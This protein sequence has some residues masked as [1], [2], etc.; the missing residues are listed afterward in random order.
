MNYMFILKVFCMILALV[1]VKLFNKEKLKPLEIFTYSLFF[2]LALYLITPNATG[3]HMKY[4]I[5]AQAAGMMLAVVS[6]KLFNKERLKPLGL[7]VYFLY[8]LKHSRVQALPSST[9]GM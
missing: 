8:S 3:G 2:I 9:E 7:F 5:F 4:M 6:V 1:A